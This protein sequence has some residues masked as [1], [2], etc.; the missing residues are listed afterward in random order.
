MISSILIQIC[1][2]LNKFNSF[3]KPFLK[4][5]IG[6]R[7]NRCQS[8]INANIRNYCALTPIFLSTIGKYS[9]QTL[10]SIAVT[11]IFLTPV[12]AD[13]KFVIYNMGGNQPIEMQYIYATGVEAGEVAGNYWCDLIL[14][15]EYPFLACEYV[16]LSEY[17]GGVLV[18]YTTN[19]GR[20][21]TNIW[22]ALVGEKVC[23]PPTLVQVDGSCT[24]VPNYFLQATNQTINAANT[25]VELG[26]S[27]SASGSLAAGN[28]IHIASGNKFQAETDLRRVGGTGLSFR[29]YYNSLDGQTTRL[30]AK[31][32]HTY[33]ALLLP[34]YG[35]TPPLYSGGGSENQ[36]TPYTTE[37]QAC[38]SGWPQIRAQY[39]DPLYQSATA[40]YANGSC[41]LYNNGNYLGTI[42]VH[43]TVY[44]WS[45]IPEVAT[46]NARRPDGKII[47]FDNAGNGIWRTSGANGMTL[48]Q[49][50]SGFLLTDK[51]DTVEEYDTN[52]WLSSITRRN[53]E[54]ETVTFVAGFLDNV[55]DNTGNTLT[56]TYDT[57]NRLATVTYNG[58]QQ[59]GYRYNSSGLLEFVDNPDN[60]T[61][62]YQYEDVNF[63]RALTGITDERSNRYATFE[64]DTAGRAFASYHAGNA[65]RVDLTYNADGSTVVTNGR[66]YATT[67]TFT[68]TPGGRKAGTITGPGCASCGSGDS[69]YEYDPA[70]SNL[71]AKTVKGLR[72]E[73]P[74]YDANGNVLIKI[75]AAGTPDARTTTYTY[76]PR[77]RS[78]V[79]T[80]TE[81][82]VCTTGNKVTTYGYDNFGNTTSI[83]VDGFTPD[84]EGCTSVSRSTA[85]QYNGPLNQLSQID[86]PRTD[87]SDITT[88]V[89]YPNDVLEGNNRGRL[90]TVTAANGIILRDNIQYTPTGKVLSE[91]RPNGISV[92]Y[93][94]YPGN[95]RLETV[96]ESDGTTSRITRWTYLPTGEVETITLGDGT[97]QATTITL[98]YDAARRLTRITDQSGNYIEYTLDTE[99]NREAE[100][101]YDS[102]GIL[103][104]TL[105]QT[106]D[107]YNRL[108]TTAQA[109]ENGDYN[110]SADGTLDTFV[111]GNAS[112]TQ[113]TYDE[114]KRLTATTQDLGG[115]DTSTAD[116]LTQY[117]YDAQ[118]NLTSVIDPINGNTIYSYDDL[119]QLLAQTSPDT[120]TTVFSYDETGNVATRLDAMGQ[121]FTYSYD[122]LNRSTLLDAPGTAD[123]ISYV[124]D[125][126]SNG[127]GRLCT[128]TQATNT[129]S[130][131]YNAFGDVTQHQGVQYAYDALGRLDTMTYPSGNSVTYIYDA[132]G[133]ISQV[134]AAVNGVTQTLA[135]GIQ[136]APFGPVINLTYGNGASLSQTFDNAYRMTSQSIPGIYQRDYSLYDA[137]GN[138]QTINDV[139]AA[140]SDVFNFDNLNR[141]SDATGTY[142]V[143]A[144]G[145]D[146][147]GNRLS[148]DENATV[149]NYVYEP[150]S[151][152]LDVAANDDVILDANGNTTSQGTRTFSYNTHNRLLSV[153]DNSTQLGSY[154]YNT[155]GQRYI[156]QA[157]TPGPDYAALAV[158]AQAEA[159][160]Y[161][162]Q[163]TAAQQQADALNLQAT[164][165]ET[166]AADLTQQVGQLQTDAAAQQQL[167]DDYTAQQQQLLQQATDYQASADNY[168]ALIVDPPESF[169]DLLLNLIYQLLVNIYTSLAEST[170]AEAD[171]VGQLAA[172]AQTQADSL[173]AQANALQTQAADLTAQAQ[174]LQ[175]QAAALQQQ[176]T[177]F[178][179]LAV[180]AQ[181]QADEYTVL[182]GNPPSV[183]VT[184]NYA[185]DLAGQ[186]I[187]EYG[188][189]GQA[190]QEII[191]LGNTPLAVVQQG[192][193]YYLHTDHLGTPRRATDSQGTVVWS[194]DSDPF[195]STLPNED[196]DG[197][198]VNT[199]INLRFSGQYFDQE[200]GLHYNYFR[201]Y[202]PSTGRYITSD[203]I[204]LAGGLNTYGYVGGNPLRWYDPLG[205]MSN[206]EACISNCNLLYKWDNLDTEDYF[207]SESKECAYKIG[208]QE[209]A[210]TFGT[211]LGTLYLDRSDKK[212]LKICL[213]NCTDECSDGGC[214]E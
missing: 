39:T 92:S 61:R 38:E 94:Y 140:T 71:L 188:D 164:T 134:D 4:S 74:D 132:N 201:Y 143:L 190:V 115:T 165:L 67:Y 138:L 173:N 186:L 155:L 153:S 197:D 77:F 42:A 130:Y 136:Y 99:G 26:D 144:Y 108:D 158:A 128:L 62:Q 91:D 126:C 120:G 11:G 87:V 60:T 146:K 101:V 27:C 51:N 210:C 97:T 73:Y 152:R 17:G 112:T 110:F 157:G 12:H 55:T 56:F 69:S 106:F 41:A 166:Q 103:K 100:N 9:S 156:K 184:T 53:G 64:Y 30:G 80:K 179:V 127:T 104:R 28:P 168:T 145:Y 204:G 214:E 111:D 76:D 139:I 35:S 44:T 34:T 72:T 192:S 19:L 187:G 178:T 118:D 200:T 114:L 59:W 154:Q 159:D 20:V 6:N 7:E 172:A 129:T 113:Y 75:E 90:Q 16:G 83:T 25:N 68:Q 86:G 13:S 18:N 85:L 170:Q 84:S 196:P 58:T 151:N 37:A 175:A 203:P 32:N 213:G 78:K 169:W 8:T 70:N 3:T 1:R 22:A 52:G 212:K 93:S 66:G 10:I 36:T 2:L 45:A 182:A 163:A 50:T 43:P 40:I 133:Q 123:D 160:A 202:D 137:N 171:A 194:W 79:T 208:R 148:L 205:L 180:Q 121:G 105:T 102:T 15:G 14:T 5:R 176:A 135:S 24:D 167:A 33:T 29:R 131:V 117:G 107:V 98:S 65:D 199:T 198:G 57:N 193:V 119:G 141:L 96:T 149:S 207:I 209:E 48:E 23:T 161:S 142:G 177:D 195:G 206:C 116:A 31:W 162:A 88:L 185:Y 95:D 82:S 181:A 63:P 89:Y 211:A 183:V 147:N 54:K 49:T 189:Q 109:N 174:D 81:P 125:T 191:Y 150:N 122:A 47:R 124:Y 46:W 21:Y